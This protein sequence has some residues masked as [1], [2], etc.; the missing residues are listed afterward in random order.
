MFKTGTVAPNVNFSTPNPAIKWKEYKLRVPVEAE[1]LPCRS[2]S[3]RS[4]VAMT[5]SGITG[6]NGHCVV[7]GPP[8]MPTTVNT[9]WVSGHALPVLLV[10]GG[11]SPTS[12]GSVAD[13]MKKVVVS[14]SAQ[15]LA[16]VYGRRAR[17]LTWRGFTVAKDG[18]E[19]HFTSPTLVPKSQPPVVFVFSGQGPQHI[20][21]KPDFL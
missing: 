8:I 13:A 17:S 12:A 4:L 15:Q 14:Y 16:R 9:F 2:S 7:E 20:H 10:A 11:L 1:P 3:G 6:A 5:S 21:S 19:L 18:E